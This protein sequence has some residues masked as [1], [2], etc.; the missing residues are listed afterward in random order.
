MKSAENVSLFYVYFPFQ[1]TYEK[2]PIVYSDFNI[3]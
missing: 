1:I 3:I 2:V